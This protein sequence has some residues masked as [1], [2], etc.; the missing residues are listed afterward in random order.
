MTTIAK[1]ASPSRSY[2]RPVLYADAATCLAT[3]ALMTLGAGPLARLFA[4]PQPLV[5][6]SGLS[7]FPIAALML[8]VASRRSIPRTG[9][10]VV[11]LGNV[12]W[13]LGS[14]LS[15]YLTTPSTLGYAFVIAQAAVVAVLADL[16]LM[17]LRR[18][19]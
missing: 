12:A 17:A 9:A 15:L 18:T 16:E 14:V 2:L 10:W 6:W 4:L 8:W 5:S 1:T 19:T 7:L 13:I 11:V 3:G